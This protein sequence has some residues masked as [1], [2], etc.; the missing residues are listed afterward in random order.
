MGDHNEQLVGWR[1]HEEA[2]L[3]VWLATSPIERLRW[4]DGAKD[5]AA[6]ALRAAE[7]RG[8]R[9]E[10]PSELSEASPPSVAPFAVGPR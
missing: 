8:V 9:M 10:N 2:Q 6:K 3:L 7:A 4:L 5:F 1:E